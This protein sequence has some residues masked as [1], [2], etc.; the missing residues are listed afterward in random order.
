[1][2]IS[3]ATLKRLFLGVG[4]VAVATGLFQLTLFL[5]SENQRKRASLP[6]KERGVALLDDLGCSDCHQTGS[7]LR[8]PI[9]PGLFGKAVTLQDGTTVVADEDYLRRSIIDPKAQVV[10][11]YQATMPSYQ[12]QLDPDDIEAIIAAMK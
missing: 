4:A 3:N 12:G 2:A 10:Q 5:R 8:A 7:P 11:G 1:M 6:I 9:L